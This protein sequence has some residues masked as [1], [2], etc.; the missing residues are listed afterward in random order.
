M[1]PRSLGPN[2]G[3]R[4]LPHPRQ[5]SPCRPG[6]A[7]RPCP[8]TTQGWWQLKCLCGSR[9][10]VCQCLQHR[11]CGGGGQRGGSSPEQS[12]LGRASAT[13]SSLTEQLLTGP[14]HHAG[15]SGGGP[16]T[17][18][19][20]R[21]GNRVAG[22]VRTSNYVTGQRRGGHHGQGT[23]RSPWTGP[24]LKPGHVLT[25]VREGARTGGAREGNTPRPT[26]EGARGHGEG[27]KA[28]MGHHYLRGSKNK[29]TPW[30][31]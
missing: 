10:T 15:C 8:H 19:P 16:G 9:G 7:G 6:G 13:H 20:A 22:L 18:S 11:Q 24:W 27:K 28:R 1:S 12:Q 5:P 2:S 31:L 26:V 25:A 21:T 17:G 30:P 3:P 4:R 14:R 29:H 23:D